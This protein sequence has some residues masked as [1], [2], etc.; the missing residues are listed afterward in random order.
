M[1][2]SDF[3]FP[4]VKNVMWLSWL[5]VQVQ[6]LISF[7]CESVTWT[8][9]LPTWV[10]L[11][12][13]MGNSTVSQPWVPQVWVRFWNSG[14]IA[15]LQPISA[16]LRVLTVLQLHHSQ[17][18]KDSMYGSISVLFYYFSICFMS[19]C[20]MINCAQPHFLSLTPIQHNKVSYQSLHLT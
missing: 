11:G 14:P 17:G 19:H 8:C 15:I 9:K 4:S 16:V 7:V 18:L 3:H 2:T 6:P 5:C 12:N 13:N 1:H 20:D 10:Y